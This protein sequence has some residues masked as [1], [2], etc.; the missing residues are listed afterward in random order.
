[1]SIFKFFD[2]FIRGKSINIFNYGNMSRNFTHV[3][4]VVSYI[5]NILGNAPKR[6]LLSN[7]F[8]NVLNIGS[9]DKIRLTY[10]IYIISRILKKKPMIKYIPM[11]KGDINITLADI[12]ETYSSTLIY[13]S[14]KI[15]EGIMEFYNWF[16]NYKTY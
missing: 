9:D 15:E 10:V 14:I 2:S 16:K 1:M 12:S 3:K 8:H 6:N 4:D 11:Q 5:L 7:S 13:P